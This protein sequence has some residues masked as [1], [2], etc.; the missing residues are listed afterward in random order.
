LPGLASFMAAPIVAVARGNL[1]HG[2][3]VLLTPR[4]N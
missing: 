1:P 3:H 2:S 4:R